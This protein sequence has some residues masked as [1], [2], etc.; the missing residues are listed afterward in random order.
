M[1]AGA[2][3]FLPAVR[4]DVLAKAFV[5]VCLKGADTDVLENADINDIGDLESKLLIN[6]FA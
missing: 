6:S 1:G 5:K 4:V 2:S 3:S